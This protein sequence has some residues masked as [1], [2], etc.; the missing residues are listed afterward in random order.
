M[1]RCVLKASNV[2]FLSSIMSSLG[3]GCG[4]EGLGE[5]FPAGGRLGY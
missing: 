2:L 4:P 3:T 5:G 1:R